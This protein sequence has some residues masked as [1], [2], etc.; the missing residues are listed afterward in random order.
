[1]ECLYGTESNNICA[2]C[3]LHATGVTAKQMRQKKCLSKQCRHLE[4]I[5]THE[6]WSQRERAKAK[7]KDRKIRIENMIGG[8]VIE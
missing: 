8:S 7:R 5:E 3:K 4:K 2:I 1:M 6:Y